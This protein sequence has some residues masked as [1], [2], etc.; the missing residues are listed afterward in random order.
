MSCPF[1]H[2]ID[3]PEESVPALGDGVEDEDEDPEGVRRRHRSPP[4]PFPC[5]RAAVVRPG[6]R[7]PLGEP[8]AERVL[9]R[10]VPRAERRSKTVSTI[11]M[12][13]SPTWSM[14]PFWALT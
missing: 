2:G 8:V 12:S 14:L 5:A 3:R 6:D 9:Q 7:G 10:A 13:R 4:S 1:V 11:L